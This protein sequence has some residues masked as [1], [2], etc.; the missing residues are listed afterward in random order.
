MQD[1]ESVLLVVLIM[2]V[3]LVPLYG[4]YLCLRSFCELLCLEQYYTHVA[5]QRENMNASIIDIIPWPC[6]MALNV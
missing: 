4:R 2:L 3:V 5:C 6:S 1:L